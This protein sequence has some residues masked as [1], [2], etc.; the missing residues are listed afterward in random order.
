MKNN[1]CTRHQHKHQKCQIRQRCDD[2][3]EKKI[4]IKK[5]EEATCLQ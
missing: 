3:E 2:G 1:V 5:K 4:Y